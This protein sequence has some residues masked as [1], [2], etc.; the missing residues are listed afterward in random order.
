MLVQMITKPLYDKKCDIVQYV[1]RSLSQ[2]DIDWHVKKST[3][4]FDFTIYTEPEVT[5]EIEPRSID[6]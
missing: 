2:F 6:S 4:S 5:F 1:H 3:V